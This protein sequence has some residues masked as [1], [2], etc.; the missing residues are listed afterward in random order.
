MS[1]SARGAALLVLA[2]LLL[3]L[4]CVDIGRG[5]FTVPVG[6]VLD[7]FAG[8]GTRSERFVIMDVRLPRVLVGMLAGA[9]LGIAGALTQSTLRNPLA[10]PDILGM[11]AGASAA[12]VAVLVFDA[13]V[14][15]PLAAVVGGLTTAFLIYMFAWRKGFDGFRLVLIG[16][17]GNA[18]LLA[19]INWLM[20]YAE[21]ED[22]AR[23][24]IWL[25]GSLD[26][27]DWSQL[28]W[29]AGGFVVAAGLALWSAP[30][31]AVL[32]FGDDK[33][34]SLG[35]RLQLRQAVIVLAA[36]VLASL[37]TAA[38]GPIAFVALAAPQIAKRVLR[39]PIEPIV[40]S[41]AIGSILVI[42]GDV[43]AR[44]VLPV[45]LPVGVVTAAVG[46]VLLLYLLAQTNRKVSV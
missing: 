19:V 16:V 38:T 35:V 1:R 18:M 17:A 27:A 43:V 31:I 41:A 11:T 30:T 42:G 39:C 6:R 7:V 12:A 28:W 9:A 24:Q 32:R 4:V 8:G 26:A 20:V 37:A 29:L 10:S 46:G 45:A 14:A 34:R 22:V 5:E 2:G 44:T 33:A 15:V 25:N 23:A 13:T 40:A 36:V 3:V 21:I